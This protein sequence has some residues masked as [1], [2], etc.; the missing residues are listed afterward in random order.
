MIAGNAIPNAERHSAPNN[1]MKSPRRGIRTA[2]TT[3]E[4]ELLKYLNLLSMFGVLAKNIKMKYSLK[5]IFSQ[6]S[7]FDKFFNL[8]VK[9]TIKT[10]NINSAR[11]LCGEFS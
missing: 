9:K 1:E 6:I 2:N 11:P 3:K 10:R 4:R 8:H 5:H 7:K